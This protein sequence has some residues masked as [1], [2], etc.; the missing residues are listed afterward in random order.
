MSSKE[1][2][3]NIILI[4]KPHDKISWGFIDMSNAQN[5]SFI[6]QQTP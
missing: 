5:F 4:Q 2:I 3:L 6:N 1:N